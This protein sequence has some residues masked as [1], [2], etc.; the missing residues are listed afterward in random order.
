MNKYLAPLW[1]IIILGTVF[2]SIHF[3]KPSA[4]PENEDIPKIETLNEIIVKEKPIDTTEQEKSFDQYIAAGD[5]YYSKGIF[6]EAVDNYENA[7]IINPDSLEVLA[8]LGEA[9]L[10]NNQPDKAR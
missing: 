5:D 10:K 2:L 1:L 9:S 8:K 6:K 7:S 3:F 4:H